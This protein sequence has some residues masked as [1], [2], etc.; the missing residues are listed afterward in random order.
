M[1]SIAFERPHAAVDGNVRRVVARLTNDG[2]ADVD[3][4]AG[5]LLDRKNPGRWNQAVMELGATICLPREPVCEACPVAKYCAAK[6][7][8]TQREIPVKRKKPEA[9]FLEKTLLVIRSGGRLLLT[10][11]VRVAGFWDLPEPF[12]GARVGAKL[13]EFK[14]TITHRHYCFTVREASVKKIP[15]ATVWFD[16]KELGEIPLSTTAKKGLRVGLTKE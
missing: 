15:A 9:E 7:A 8:G 4:I 1:A 6:I 3:R 5:E 11:S 14:H 10:P 12:R 13:G 2:F 16:E